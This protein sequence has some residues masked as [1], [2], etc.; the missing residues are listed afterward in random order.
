VIAARK[1]PSPVHSNPDALFTPPVIFLKYRLVFFW[2]TRPMGVIMRLFTFPLSSAGY[3]LQISLKTILQALLSLFVLF[4]GYE[5]MVEAFHMLNQ[6]SDRAV[7]MG[8][9]ILAAL[10]ILVPIVLW[11]LWRKKHG[12]LW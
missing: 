11:Q 3:A 12:H 4:L 8:T 9:A 10:C 2:R 6:P 5:C 1:T 7:Y